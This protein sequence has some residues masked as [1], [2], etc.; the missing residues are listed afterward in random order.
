MG[1]AE[2]A[3]AKTPALGRPRR[4]PSGLAFKQRSALL[5]T[6]CLIAPL[7]AL[8]AESTLDWS[9]RPNTINLQT[10]TDV[11]TVD[12]VTITTSGA[13][14]GGRTAT[15]FQLQ[16]GGTQNGFSG[17]IQS[18]MN[19]TTDNG[20]VF[21][22]VTFTF[23]EPVYNLRFVT[24]DIDAINDG[25]NFFT[26][27]VNFS[28]DGGVPTSAS[29]G[30]SIGYTAATGVALA[31]FDTNCT[32]ND[33]DCQIEVT[34]GNALTSATVTHIAADADGNTNPTNQAI[35]YRDLVFNTPPDATNNT[36]ALLSTQTATGNVLTDDD[37]SGTDSDRQDGTDVFV[38]QISHPDATVAVSGATVL[39]L[40]NGATLT[41]D[42]NGD[43]SFDPNGAYN[44]LAD[45]ATTTETFTYRIED[46][47]GLF[48]TD[49]DAVR[50]DSLG[51]LTVTITGS[52]TPVPAFTVEKTVDQSS[53]TAPGTLTY[54]ISVDN[55]GSVDLTGV[56]LSDT[57]SQG[58][59][60]LSLTIGPTLSGDTDSD[61][62]LDTTETWVYT[63]TY[64][65][66]SANIDDGGDII[67]IATVGTNETTG[68]QTASAS[69]T[70]PGPTFACAGDDFADANLIS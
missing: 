20:S 3:V 37:G 57:I 6:T 26:D 34:F 49:G 33:A 67:N 8:A 23:S 53:I 64:N 18:L 45:G 27:Q 31:G 55:T 50:P 2:A 9:T 4:R 16:P 15:T 35:Q 46:Q 65:A 30:S 40:T 29:V 13:I 51:T 48:N 61:G 54:T 25:T 60:I 68:T 12:G 43:Y 44:G 32:G 19:G 58:T 36:A 11:A 10:A 70:T 62:Q 22:T 47:E 5:L 41:I 59:T 1:L 39:T 14:A 63:A 17:M 66:T 42:E 7:P 38:N 28:S 56:S 52:S 24:A 69:T 21:N